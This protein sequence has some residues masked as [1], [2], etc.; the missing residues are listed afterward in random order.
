[1]LVS[2]V[3]PTFNRAGLVCKAINSVLAQSHPAFEIIVVDDGSKDE[4]RDRIKV[5]GDRIR[6]VSQE[7]GGLSRARNTGIEAALGEWVAF[8]DD[9]DEFCPDKL[10][11]HA[12]SALRHPNLDVHATN[13][14]LMS[15]SGERT[16][17][18]QIRGAA[19]PGRCGVL[20]R[21][22]LWITRGCFFTQSVMFRRSALIDVGMYDPAMIYEDLDLFSR[23]PVDRPW[24]IDAREGVILFRRAE[25]TY[26]LS[27]GIVDKP[28]VSYAC[29][30]KIYSRILDQAA[31]SMHEQAQIRRMLAGFRFELGAAHL[32]EGNRAEARHCFVQ[33]MRDNPTF[34]TRVKGITTLA[35]GDWSLSAL[36]LLRSRRSGT[37]RSAPRVIPRSA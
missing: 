11:I 2:V 7:N 16:N 21:P 36:K 27:Q 8:L 31:L 32:R 9:D 23:L 10:A 25:S 15:A 28:L 24:G 35:L 4:T 34:R 33:A 3:I 20:A 37:R 22:L 12:E 29:L 5:Y 30:V 18:W 14:V 6:Y 17:L 1:M 19:D 13:T 26:N